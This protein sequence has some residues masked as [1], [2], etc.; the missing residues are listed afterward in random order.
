MKLSAAIMGHPKRLDFINDLSRQLP[1]VRVVLDRKNDRWDT[2]ARALLGYELGATHHLVVQDDAILCKDFL[3]GCELVAEQA[4]DH[5]V[6]LYIGQVRPHVQMVSP[7]VAHVRDSGGVWLRMGGPWWGVAVIIPVRYIDHMVAWGATRRHIANY[8]KRMS[9]Y[10][11]V[12]HKID[13]WYTVPSLV[14]HRSEDE[15]PSLVPGR[16]GNRRAQYFIGDRSPLDIDWTTPP[17][18]L[19]TMFR[20]RNGNRSARRV[21][22]GGHNYMRMVRSDKWEEVA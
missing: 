7:A 14:D 6:S 20:S 17:T 2:G 1:G 8:D 13:C 9:H 21:H 12:H 18:P 22:V 16:R 5:P 10:F 15:N 3:A 19:M 4:G 11:K